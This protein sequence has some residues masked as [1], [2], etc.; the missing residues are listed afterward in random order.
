[1]LLAVQ[2]H[3]PAKGMQRLSSR[4]QSRV[5]EVGWKIVVIVYSFSH[6]TSKLSERP[7]KYADQKAERGKVLN[8]QY[9]ID[10]DQPTS[11]ASPLRINALLSRAFRCVKP[12]A[13]NQG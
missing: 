8:P 12:K 11:P 13:E 9:S 2:V 5:A 1:M 4:L 3:G 6:I 7:L 10:R